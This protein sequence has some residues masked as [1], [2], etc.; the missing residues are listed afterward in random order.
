M[1]LT[2]PEKHQFA[3]MT[4]SA[5]PRPVFRRM[6]IL[7][8][9]LLLLGGLVFFVS[10][11]G[12]FARNAATPAPEVAPPSM[13]DV[14][15]S[16]PNSSVYCLSC[17][18][19]VGLAT[20][21]L[22]VQRGHSHNVPLN[23]TQLRAV[24]DLGTLVGP[25]NTLICMSCHTLKPNG[26]PY[27]LADTLEDSQLCQRCHP[28]HY[29]R[30]TPHDL[31]RSAPGEKNCRGQTAE[32]GG[33]CSACHLAHSYA[34]EIIP[35]PLDPDGW[36]ITCHRSYGVAAEHARTQQMQHPE[37]QCLHC[38][39][40]HDTEHGKFLKKS[41]PELCLECHKQYDGG[42]AA[43]MHPLT[44]LEQPIPQNLRRNRD[45]TPTDERQVTC[46]TCHTVHEAGNENLLVVSNRTNE[47][48]LS[49]HQQQLE[50][51]GAGS[52]SRH[53]Q[54]PPLNDAQ[55]EVVARWGTPMGAN[56][57]LLCVSCHRVH[58]AEPKAKLLVF[59]PKYGDTCVACHPAQGSVQGTL[60][61][62]T[63]KFPLAQNKAGL[64]PVGAGVCSACH[65]AHEFPRELV[66]G[67][68]DEDGR[69]LSCHLA[70]R[71]AQASRSGGVEHPKTRCKEC[72]NP[73]GSSTER[74]LLQPQEQLC[75][76]CHAEK[77]SL[78]GGPHDLAQGRRLEKWTAA[79]REHGG[80][81]LSC[82]VP[83]GGERQD[84]FRVG[85][86]ETLG[87]QDEP[88]LACHAD[89]T[90]N[91]TEIGAIHPREIPRDQ[92]SIDKALLKRDASG[93]LRIGC[94]TCHDPHGGQEAENLPR[95]RSG[96]S[97]E[98]LCLKCH[99]DKKYIQQTGHAADR[100]AKLKMATD[101]CKPCHAMH[102]D[103]QGTW[104]Q[105][106]SARF[107][108]RCETI[109]GQPECIP[110]LSCHRENGPA[111]FQ[112]LASHPP[113]RLASVGRESDIGH[114]PLFNAAGHEDPQGEVTC[115][116]CHVSHG[117][118]DLL[119]AIAEN[120][121][122]TPAQQ[123]AMRAQLRP[124]LEPNTCTACHDSAQARLLFLRFHD[125]RV[126]NQMNQPVR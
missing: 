114:L 61:D 33:P 17:H 108:P 23:E 28:G 19:N 63:I 124:F 91:A 16:G 58:G 85:A 105:M 70:G 65:L 50:S 67:P 9:A 86:A 71:L 25:D 35:S 93:E 111:P 110:C 53:A 56:G 39:N 38:H 10:A 40:S 83:H 26:R 3:E 125:A 126:R 116:T 2:Q 87:S 7:L 29:A 11:T 84:L 103:R 112:R 48:C 109:K 30:N 5:A 95:V 98:T 37:S 73:H 13:A 8:N 113:R 24:R 41:P 66:P 89:N 102:A 123:E 49:C 59:Q 77:M 51:H 62:L 107:L 42:P 6:G 97:A 94:G 76:R 81:C 20:A 18:W 44:R 100:L 104:G 101:S 117:R 15:W 47:L 46:A 122:W 68:G 64:T 74:F 14:D 72:H 54:S 57:E 1:N 115:R 45:A 4:D 21:G 106:L 79:T 82:H 119:K 69:C 55:R 88:C 52:L 22:D 121:D 34:R 96:E 80:L 75:E 90:W 120:P 78:R 92:D 27:M 32:A 31:R 36:C 43:G 118:L 12:R 60:H 99:V